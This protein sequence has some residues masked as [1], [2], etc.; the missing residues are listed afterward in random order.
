MSLDSIDLPQGR[1]R[2]HALYVRLRAAILSGELRPGERLVESSLA[3]RA[4]VSRTP[5]RQALHH[6]ESDGLVRESEGG[7]VEV[8]GFSLDEIA[9]LCAVRE[10]L[11]GMATGLAAVSCSA[12]ELA[13]L[14]NVLE[15]E[16]EALERDADPEVQV[17]LNHR[18]HE[19][20]WR[21]ARNRYL[22]G[23]LR[24]LRE[25]IEQR[26]LSTL[27]SVERQRVALEEHR[28]IFEAVS[29]HDAE[30]AERLAREHFRNAMAARLVAD[31][32]SFQIPPA[33]DK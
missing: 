23:E 22:V 2:A 9:D 12:M 20:L 1:S 8:F 15:A 11:E 25:M 30:N 4:G 33:H 21:A 5:V 31:A 24:S 28:R 14:R 17:D 10:A 3:Q 16:Q 7:G 32:D 6:L 19:T 27:R 29:Q 18:F 26:Q 13:M